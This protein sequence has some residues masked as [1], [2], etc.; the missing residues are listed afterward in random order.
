MKSD[1]DKALCEKYPKIFADRHGDMK[2]TAM[3]WGFECGDGWYQ[4]IDG[5]CSLIQNH[6][7]NSVDRCERNKEFL[8][9]REA[10]LA[11][12]WTLFDEYNSM[13]K[14]VSA[15]WIES[16]KADVLDE[17]PAWRI[18]TN[19]IH[20]VV[21]TQVKEKFGTLRFYHNG[22]DDMIDGMVYMAEEMSSRTCEVCGNPGK[23]S[24][25]GWLKTTCEEHQ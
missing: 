22:G 23:T 24:G 12:D 14:N 6:I 19:P 5:L 18:N 2:T 10:A 11:G 13:V 8:K 15:E 25:S 3:C 16:R 4:L 7:D 21:A 9:M 1:L 17:P 20:Q